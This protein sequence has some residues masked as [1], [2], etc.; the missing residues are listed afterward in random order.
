ML[1]NHGTTTTH[2]GSKRPRAKTNLDISDSVK[3]LQR[4]PPTAVSFS[5]CGTYLAIAGRKIDLYLSSSIGKAASPIATFEPPS[6]SNMITALSFSVS[7]S[8][9]AVHRDG[10]VLYD[11][12]TNSNSNEHT[13]LD[14]VGT[15][16]VC[17]F[18]ASGTLVAVPTDSL[19]YVIDVYTHKSMVQLE[20]HGATVTCLAFNPHR[21]TQLATA[22]EDRSFKLW[23][24]QE[25]CLLY[26]SAIISSS[27]FTALAF[28]PYRERL[29][30]GSEDGK[31]RFYMLTVV[32]HQHQHQHQDQHYDAQHQ[33]SSSM[34]PSM[35]P[36][37]PATKVH[38]RE[39]HTVDVGILL[40]KRNHLITQRNQEVTDAEIAHAIQLDNNPDAAPHVI[41]SLPAW[42]REMT[43]NENDHATEEEGMGGGDVELD[44][45]VLTLHFRQD[46]RREE[47]RR[48]NKSQQ[49]RKQQGLGWHGT[50]VINGEEHDANENEQDTGILEDTGD[51]SGP[52]WK[53]ST[54]WLIVGTPTALV[55]VD[56]A[57]Y[58]IDTVL[59]FRDAHQQ[60][61]PQE[62]QHHHQH[63]G[64][65]SSSAWGQRKSNRTHSMPAASAA[66]IASFIPPP[67]PS[68]P[69][70]AAS[71]LLPTPNQRGNN[72][73]RGVLSPLSAQAMAMG[74]AKQKQAVP[75]DLTASCFAFAYPQPPD[76][77]PGQPSDPT[78][79]QDDHRA[80]RIEYYKRRLGGGEAS[81]GIGVTSANGKSTSSCSFVDGLLCVVGSAFAPSATVLKLPKE[82]IDFTPPTPRSNVQKTTTRVAALPTTAPTGSGAAVVVAAPALPPPLSLFPTTP[83]SSASP[84][85]QSE[86]KT[87]TKAS[88]KRR[89]GKT[90][91]A[92]QNKPVT[93]HRN[94]RSS[95]YGKKAPVMA[96]HGKKKKR[97]SKYRTQSNNSN[98]SSS[99]NSSNSTEQYPLDCSAPNRHQRVHQ[100]AMDGPN[101]KGR[102]HN[103]PIT[104]VKYTRDATYVATCSADR[105]ATSMRLP[106]SK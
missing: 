22:S 77:L 80:N 20:G 44:T 33:T 28:D 49:Q 6:A 96:L 71:S 78:T 38:V 63:Q 46:A 100:F 66:P 21:P 27:P 42:A 59:N 50:G 105:T 7:L 2:R 25:R 62:H 94:I 14:S 58:E 55:H 73:L 52:F 40:R 72:V 99:S 104:G 83:L 24:I 16:C 84:L 64:P 1:H 76:Q 34:L 26:Q 67:A 54:T 41:S 18:N 93:F 53:T 29:A 10:A 82:P 70:S 19:V 86:F 88:N 51:Q 89:N 95:G 3:L 13:L 15:R 106:C 81:N 9:C 75:L 30:V 31:L 69:P 37:Q 97:P 65:I 11:D 90:G 101:L 85:R 32:E 61:H 56:T 4:V 79:T 23:D 8:L 92:V 35:L 47:K 91:S 57:S 45:T 60:E 12:A 103:G 43:S 39:E 68:S 48:K 17:S 87:P 98:N 36:P 5:G 74:T 102:L